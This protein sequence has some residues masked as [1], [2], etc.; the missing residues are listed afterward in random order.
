MERGK[1][2]RNQSIVNP[3]T[4][5][6]LKE[7]IFYLWDI[8]KIDVSY[9]DAFLNSIENQPRSQ[10]VQSLAK[11]IENLYNEKAEIQKLYTQIQKREVVLAEIQQINENITKNAISKELQDKAVKFLEELRDHTLLVIELTTKLREDLCKN[12]QFDRNRKEEWI[13]FPIIFEKQSYLSK[14]N[15]DYPMIITSE[16]SKLFKFS[17]ALDPFFL[18]PSQPMPIPIASKG[19]PPLMPGPVTLKNKNTPVKQN[20][21]IKK[22]DKAAVLYLPVPVGALYKRIKTAEDILLEESELQVNKE[23]KKDEVLKEMEI[24]KEVEQV[25]KKTEM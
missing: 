24:K 13:K 9:R 12:A 21:N 5:T 4:I 11:E 6:A 23:C 16:L 14:I 2:Y 7:E 25:V 15:K 20:S 19:K 3:K 10:Q 22:N 17:Q 18:T 1:I 8:Y